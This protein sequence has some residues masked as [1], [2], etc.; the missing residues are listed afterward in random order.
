MLWVRLLVKSELLV[1]CL[2]VKSYT[3]IFYCVRWG[4][5]ACLTSMFFKGQC[6]FECYQTYLFIDLFREHVCTSGG[7]AERE[8][9][10]IPSTLSAQSPTWDSVSQTEIMI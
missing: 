7:G 9:E 5:L 1:K 4:L 3:Q 2:G 6:R 8:G 10:R